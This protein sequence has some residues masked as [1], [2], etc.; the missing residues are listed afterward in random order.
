M[1]AN[2][3]L[4]KNLNPQNFLKLDVLFFPLIQNPEY[5]ILMLL[6]FFQQFI[7]LLSPNMYEYHR[8]SH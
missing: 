1:L 6:V 3:N 2:W 4:N 5:N 7:P 8:Y